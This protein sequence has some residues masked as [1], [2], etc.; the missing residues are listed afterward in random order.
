VY[1]FL[2]R[3]KARSITYSECVCVCLALGI[4]HAKRTRR[5]IL[6]PVACLDL[7]FFF[8]LSHKRH[9]FLEKV[10]EQTTRKKN[11]WKTEETL[12]RAVVT[13]E[14]ERIKGSNP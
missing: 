14:T 3:G 6:S 13:L 4:Q 5:S 9:N 10:N 11:N 7:T 1:P 2:R 8:T 12:A